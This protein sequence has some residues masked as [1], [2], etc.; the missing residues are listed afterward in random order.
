[1]KT[2]LEGEMDVND[3][4]WTREFDQAALTFFHEGH[5]RKIFFWNEQ[6]GFRYTLSQP[7]LLLNKDYEYS[8]FVFF[9]K[10]LQEDQKLNLDN[11][12]EGVNHSKVKQNYML[13]LLELL[14]KNF[15]PK[16]Y[17]DTTWPENVKKQFLSQLH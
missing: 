17:S 7:P 2:I 1:M 14:D 12:E 13:T 16:I 3:T 10:V 4:K 6:E 8:E 15:N 9:V 11:V 5:Q